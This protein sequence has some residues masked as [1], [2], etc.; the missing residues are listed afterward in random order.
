VNYAGAEKEG[1]VYR[2]NLID[3]GELAGGDGEALEGQMEL[4]NLHIGWEPEGDN[5]I[6]RLVIYEEEIEKLYFCCD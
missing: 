5:C 4:E 1:K 3:A 6:Y 2:P